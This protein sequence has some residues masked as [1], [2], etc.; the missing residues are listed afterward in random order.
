MVDIAFVNELASSSPT[1]GGGAA[2][3]YC[4]MLAAALSSMVGELTVGKPKYAD[5]K[6]EVGR[7]LEDLAARRVRLEQLVEEDAAAFSP[8]AETYRMPKSTPEERAAKQEAQQRALVSA[9]SVPLAIMEQCAD[10]IDDCAV[11]VEK[12]TPFAISDAGGSALMAKAALLSASLSVIANVQL[13]KDR[14]RAEEIAANAQRLV[15]E[16]SAKADALYDQVRKAME[17]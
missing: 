14:G 5:V 2:S 8:L 9:C 10:V 16:Y 12:G 17:S 11:M 13:M 1:P 15:D 7:T 3:A 6:E 4:G